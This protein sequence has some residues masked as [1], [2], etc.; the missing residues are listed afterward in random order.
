MAELVDD[1]V[2]RDLGRPQ[3]RPSFA[4]WS[5]AP[6]RPRAPRGASVAPAASAAPR[7][8]PSTRAYRDRQSELASASATSSYDRRRSV[9]SY[10]FVVS[11]SS[12]A[13]VRSR[14]S[15]KPAW[16]VSGEPTTC[17]AVQLW[18]NACWSGVY[19][20]AAAS[21]GEGSVDGWPERS[22]RNESL[23]GP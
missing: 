14:N 2:V 21:S 3:P 16:T 13:F 15:S 18:T 11:I 12:S 5:T 7:P 4:G 1:D 23:A 17:E 9:W 8:L 6:A 19:G 20:K 10:T 22:R